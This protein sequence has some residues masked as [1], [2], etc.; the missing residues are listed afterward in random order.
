M[1][2][3]PWKKRICFWSLIASLGVSFACLAYPVYVIRPFRHQG[4]RELLLALA[5]IRVRQPIVLVCAV[6]AL[7]ALAWYWHL[8]SQRWRRIVAVTGA[9]FVCTFAV[10]SHVNLYE[11]MFHPAGHPEFAAAQQVK[12]DADEMV[13]AVKLGE[14]ARAYPIRS[15]SYH[16][17]INDVLGHEPIVATY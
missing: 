9:L 13:I 7:A 11:L 8:Q 6:L 16:H 2:H 14:D 1:D 15:I 10:L 5:V 3:S 12:L 4:P 17:V